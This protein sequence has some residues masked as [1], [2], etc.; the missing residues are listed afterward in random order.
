MGGPLVNPTEIRYHPSGQSGEKNETSG[1]RDRIDNNHT[2]FCTPSFFEDIERYPPGGG[3]GTRLDSST[4]ACRDIGSIFWM[5]ICRFLG[6][7][8]ER[9]GLTGPVRGSP[10][11]ALR[12]VFALALRAPTCFYISALRSDLFQRQRSTL[13]RSL[14]LHA[15]AYSSISARRSDLLLQ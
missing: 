15:P 2:L 5:K 7:C 10:P 8:S 11:S 1:A 13:R 3:D 14:A 9:L 4:G 12:P 6:L